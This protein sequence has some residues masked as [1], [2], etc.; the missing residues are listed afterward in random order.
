MEENEYE[1][2]IRLDNSYDIVE[3]ATAKTM[4]EAITKT[5]QLVKS[6]YEATDVWFMDLKI[7]K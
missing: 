3:I 2:I 1:I 6:K 5:R 7:K 4:H